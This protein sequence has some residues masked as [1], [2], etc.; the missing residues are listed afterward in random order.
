MMI[1]PPTH[2]HIR[3]DLHVHASHSR[4]DRHKP[5]DPVDY[6]QTCGEGALSEMHHYLRDRRYAYIAM[7][8][9]ATDPM[10]PRPAN[11]TSEAKIRTHRDAVM[12]LNRET[13]AEGPTLLAGVE[14]SLL[15]SG[16][17]DVSKETLCDLAIVI[18]SRH[19]GATAWS[20]DE[21]IKRLRSLF[22]NQPINVL[23][24]PTRYVAPAP[25]AR[26]RE[27][28]HLCAESGIA[29]EL[30]LRNPFGRELITEILDSGVLISLGSDLHGNILKEQ[31]VATG[32]LSSVP[33]I[34]DLQ[35]QGFPASRI[36]NT[37]PL[38]KL[39]R[40]LAEKKTMCDNTN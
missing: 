40:W 28:L 23:G 37:W 1:H 33:V 34:R 6:D 8:N 17:L 35:E 26:Y 27:L 21:T 24:H 5:G 36:V 14:T 18:A 2:W 10:N 7:V 15:P 3:G 38:A 29:F 22:D 25:L 19:G 9:H 12:K 16:E 20:M 13:Q 30:N 31:G 32:S 11:D 4:C 39:Q